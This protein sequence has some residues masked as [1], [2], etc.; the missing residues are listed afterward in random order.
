[1]TEELVLKLGGKAGQGVES[2]GAG[3]ARA[4][5]RGGL[6]V[7]GSQDY[8]S[9]IRGGH[10][11]YVVRASRRPLYAPTERIHLLLAFDEESVHLHAGEVLPGGGV[12]YDETLPVDADTI[13][14]RGAEALP[15]PLNRIAEE[16]GGSRI[17]SNTAALAAA[18]GI[19]GYG[20]EY[21]ESVI[22]DNFKKKGD[23]ITDANLKVAETAY[24]EASRRYGAIFPWKLEAATPLGKSPYVL[25]NGNQALAL[26]ALAGGCRFI[27]AYPM[28][29]ASSIFEWMIDHADQYGIV[30]KQC[31]DELAA[32]LMAIG[33]AH[34]GA[35]AMTAT[36]GGG[37]SLM[38]EALGM[39]GMMEVPVVIALAQR[40][41]PSTGMPTRTEQGD[42]L[43]ALHAS[44]GDFPRIVLAP[45]TAEEAFLMGARAFNLAEKYQLP[46][47]ILTDAFLANSVKTLERSKLSVSKVEIDRGELVS[48][49]ELDRMTDRYARYKLTASGISPRALPGHPKAVYLANSDEHTEFG[50]FEDEDAENRVRM[51]EKRMRKLDTARTE[52]R[53]PLVYGSAEPAMTLVCWGSSYGPV[54]EAVEQLNARG[55]AANLVHFCDL[56]PLSPERVKAVLAGFAQSGSRLVLVEGNITG[57]FGRLLRAETGISLEDRVLRY[58]GRPLTATYIVEKLLGLMPAAISRDGGLGERVEGGNRVA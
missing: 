35:R 32:I 22:R 14:S 16:T 34:M 38:V 4:L 41:G 23:R 55:V 7:F 45:G 15:L 9:R 43:F 47:I 26:G 48:E 51:H 10:N 8:M 33:A 46:V 6:S 39:A 13:R 57:Q 25:I 53:E 28:T 36:S 20:L 12:I 54:R 37:F 31:E 17:M 21:L 19:V 5:A 18:A 50:N 30:T 42:L 56:W 29:P 40:P 49:E 2:S 3:F 27:S 24:K 1:M 11:F 52:M 44:Q 58:D